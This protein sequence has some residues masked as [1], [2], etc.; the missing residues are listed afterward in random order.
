MSKLSAKACFRIAVGLILFGMLMQQVC[1]NPIEEQ[2]G[3]KNLTIEI[4]GSIPIDLVPVDLIQNIKNLNQEDS[5]DVYINSPGG[6]VYGGIPLINSLL[7]T[8][9]KV[10]VHVIGLAAS[11]AGIIACTGDE[12]AMD[13]NTV[14]MFHT[15][16]S[17]GGGKSNEIKADVEFSVPAY[18]KLLIRSCSKILTGDE[19]DSIMD[20]KDL[21]LGPEDVKRRLPNV[22]K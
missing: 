8:K 9:A 1:A 10:K 17:K 16:S 22:G 3:P 19:I 13:P 18:K 7:D 14:L 11:M 6:V 4:Q 12:I 5:V 2:I 15:Y 20:G 21:Y